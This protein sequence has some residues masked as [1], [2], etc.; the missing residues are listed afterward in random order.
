MNIPA[1]LLS[2]TFLLLGAIHLYWLFGGEWALRETLPTDAEGNRLLNP[3]KFDIIVV[4]LGLLF[5]S[6]VYFL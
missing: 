4:A 3:G 1:L 5:F 2:A 6:L